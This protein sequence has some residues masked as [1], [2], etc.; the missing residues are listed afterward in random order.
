[1]KKIT[2]RDI[3]AILFIVAGFTIMV[4]FKVWLAEKC[5]DTNDPMLILLDMSTNGLF[6]NA[7][8]WTAVA[9]WC[10]SDSIKTFL[11]DIISAMRH[12]SFK[13]I[14]LC[15]LAI[16]IIPQFFWYSGKFG[17]IQVNGKKPMRLQYNYYLI[18]DSIT[19]ETDTMT[20]SAADFLIKM[21]SYSSGHGRYGSNRVHY[22]YYA[23]Y[24]DNS[25]F[26]YNNPFVDYINKCKE[27]QKDIQISYYKN[28]G[29]IISID[30]IGFYDRSGFDAKLAQLEKEKNDEIAA[31]KAVEEAEKQKRPELFKA[32]YHSEGQNFDNIIND[33]ERKGI[34]NTYDVIYISTKYFETGTVALFDN[35]QNVV[36]VVRD[37]DKED[38]VEVPP[39]PY[40]STFKEVTKILDDAGIKWTFDCMGSYSKKDELDHSKD[41]L[42]TV[43]CSP[44]T[45]IP[46]DYV[47]WFSVRHAE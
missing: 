19:G 39:I 5:T 13:K 26:I 4:I 14:L 37:N 34:E 46:K 44:G 18:R 36:Y 25:M 32:F 12:S 40:D 7:I 35:P 21:Y 28:S 11:S 47:F 3:G 30:G 15:L 31:E 16:L 9:V 17:H 23:V 6:F 33:L 27:Y 20:I 2:L 10:I 42:N 41:T 38:M 22:S 45:P 8:I 43:H 24:G 29:I 1:M